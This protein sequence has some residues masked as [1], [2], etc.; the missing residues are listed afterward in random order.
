MPSG[1]D[2]DPL[3]ASWTGYGPLPGDRTADAC[4]IGLG[5]SG[6]AAVEAL[7]DRGLSVVGV[8][9]GRVACGAAG[10]NGGFLVGGAA[11]FLHDAIEQWGADAAVGL[12]RATLTELE[13]LADVLGPEVIRPTGSIRLAGLPGAPIDEAEERDQAAEVA[14]CAANL[15]AMRAHG[16]AAEEYNGE[17]GHGLFVPDDAAI[18]PAVRALTIAA[19][20]R[21]RADLYEHTVV[22]SIENGKVTNITKVTTS[23]GTV[24]A[25]VVIV[26]VDGRLDVLV[27][28]LAPTVRTA[29]LQMLRTA[30]IARRLPCPVYSRWGYDFAQSDASGRLF[31]GGGR[32][33]FVDEEWTTEAEPTQPVQ[34]YI[35]QTAARFAGVSVSVEQRWAASV[36]YTDDGRAVVTEVAPGI[37]ACGGYSGTGNLV[38]P[39]AARAAVALAIDRTPPPSYFLSA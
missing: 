13:R 7:L 38:G 5:A 37:A 35:E 32:D 4:V 12:Y 18:N 34:D 22:R 17:L 19:S 27:P 11:A 20:L 31:I 9:G 28:K 15:A 3:V 24:S 6:L 23:H 21:G 26:A 39:V 1:W 33:K 36:G 25:P 29:R 16:I 30:P 2:D 14:D 10:R 8:D